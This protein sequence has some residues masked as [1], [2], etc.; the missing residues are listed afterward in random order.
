MID[1][2]ELTVT[3]ATLGQMAKT[4]NP[5]LKQIKDAAVRHMHAFVRDVELTPEEWIDGSPGFLT[6]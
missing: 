2:D 6:A 5:R 4:A 3:D 1:L